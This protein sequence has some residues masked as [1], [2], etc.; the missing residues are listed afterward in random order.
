MKRADGLRRVEDE[1]RAEQTLVAQATE[2][3]AFIQSQKG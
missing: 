3:T 2:R 1:G